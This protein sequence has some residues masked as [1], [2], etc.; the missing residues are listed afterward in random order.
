MPT[1]GIYH[2]ALGPHLDSGCIIWGGE[3]CWWYSKI[4]GTARAPE[5]SPLFS[6]KGGRELVSQHLMDNLPRAVCALHL[7]PGIII[8][9]FLPP[10][11]ATFP[12]PGT[13]SPPHLRRTRRFHFPPRLTVH[14]GC[15]SSTT[16]QFP[17]ICSRG[18]GLRSN[19]LG[20]T[21]PRYKRTAIGESTGAG[22]RREPSGSQ[23]KNVVGWT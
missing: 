5:T 11:P 22:L 14:A 4:P 15:F 7:P 12:L 2:P 21:H 19:F 6:G 1:S 8:R 3:T 16:S 13:T 20:S 10:P 9:D 23:P 17:G 18:A